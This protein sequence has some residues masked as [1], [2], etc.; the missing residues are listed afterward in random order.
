MASTRKYEIGVGLLMV[1][2]AS[3][4]AWMSLKVGA[5]GGFGDAVQVE[6]RAPDAAG[7]SP[8]ASVAVSGV[9]IGTVDAMRIDHAHAVLTLAID[10]AAQVRSDAQARIR[11]RSI[12]GEKYV[13]LVP[14]GLDAP[15][16][17]D[18]DQ[19]V[20]HGQQTEI[21]EMVGALGPFMAAIDAEEIGEVVALLASALRDDPARI[22][23]VF[24]NLDR[25][26][27][28]AADASERLPDLLDRAERTLDRVDQTMIAATRTM[29][30]A[31]TQISAIAGP[32][33]RADALLADL[34][35]AARPLPGMMEDVEVT[36]E[37]ARALLESVDG[38]GEDLKIVLSNVKEIDKW[39]L[40]RLLR[41]EGLVVRLRSHKVVVPEAAQAD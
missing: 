38:I 15:L 34:Q 35:L 27:A 21:D 18:G 8:G 11:S 33:D 13:E 6:L 3:L 7:I 32:L 23:R 25:T 37:E 26:M 31:D 40:R 41:E 2:A 24:S 28:G 1:V 17:A 39:E 10:P 14:S 20:V 5:L 9:K 19:L 12:L 30:A 16:L 29:G 36:L 22:G 4:L